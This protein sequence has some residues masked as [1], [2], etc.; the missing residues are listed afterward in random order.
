[1]TAVGTFLVHFIFYV[2]VFDDSD[3][4]HSFDI[5][6][7]KHNSVGPRQPDGKIAIGWHRIWCKRGWIVAEKTTTY[8]DRGC[9]RSTYRVYCFGYEAFQEICTELNKNIDSVVTIFAENLFPYASADY[10]FKDSRSLE[11]YPRQ[12]EI[13]GDIIQTYM[14]TTLA[15][16]F[17]SG[18][19]GLGK[20]TLGE[21]VGRQLRKRTKMKV[22]KTALNLTAPG[23]GVLE[24]FWTRDPDTILILELNEYDVAIKTALG[25]IP[26]ENKEVS[27]YAA[28]KTSLNNLFDFFG[29]QEK[30]VI[31]ATTNDQGLFE[32][33]DKES[34]VRRFHKAV[35]Y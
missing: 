15:F 9:T 3:T 7:Q 32:Q 35:L 29:Q 8:S 2:L 25:E 28:S 27:C 11:P 5:F 19:P 6:L 18:K 23:K 17:I 24:Y 20:T 30:L 34:F 16:F 12:T 14:T 33:K 31:I 4:T 13:I 22:V 10:S 26:Y 1:V 21:L